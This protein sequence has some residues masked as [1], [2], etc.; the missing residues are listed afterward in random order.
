MADLEKTVAI[1]FQGEDKLSKSITT[2]S[3]SLDKFGGKVVSATQPLADMS[4]K[5]L[6]VEAALAAMAIGGLAL[7][8]KNAGEFGDSF[9]EISTLIDVPRENLEAFK[10]DIAEYDRVSTSSIEDINEAIYSAISA[11]TDY[12]NSLEVLATSEKLAIAG[13]ADLEATTR[14]L[15]STLNAY[16]YSVDQAARFSDVLFK[17]VK[18][19]Q[20]TLPE[21]ADGLAQVSTIAAAAGVPIETMMAGLA[22][23]T[24][25]GAPVDVAIT[26]MKGAITSLLKPSSE[27]ATLAKELGLEFGASAIK[28]KGF[29]QI[30]WDAWEATKGNTDQMAI[31]FGNVRALAG[32]LVLGSDS[33]GKFRAS[34]K[35]MEAAA[36]ATSEAYDRMAGNFALTNQKIINNLRVTL[37]EVGEPLLDEYSDIADG[38]VE[39][40][41]GLSVGIDAGAFDPV[42][43]SLENFGDDIAEFLKKVAENLPEAMEDLD[44]TEFIR[45]IEGL[46]RNLSDAFNAFFGDID[47]TTPEGLSLA[48]QKIVD[49]VTALT[50]VTSGIIDAW[51]PFLAVLGEAVE[52]FSDADASTQEITG[53]ILGFGQAINK[54]FN[55]IGLLTGALNIIAGALSFIAGKQLVASIGGFAKLG[56]TISGILPIIGKLSGLLGAGLAG[57]EIGTKLR[58]WIPAIDDVAQ[59]M[60]GLT[61][62]VFNWSG[63][64]RQAAVN[65][66]EVNRKWAEAQER[67][68]ALNQT[69]EDTPDRKEIV[70]EILDEDIAF[71][72][73]EGFKSA[74]DSIPDEKSVTAK[75]EVDT[76]SFDQIENVIIEYVPDSEEIIIRAASD[77]QSFE[78]TKAEIDEKIPDEKLMEI[79][80]QGDIETEIARINALADT[81]QSSVEWNAKLR[82]AEFEANS[83][84]VIAIT[85]SIATGLESTGDVLSAI[86]G[87]FGEISIGDQLS[88]ERYL[89]R[90]LNIQRD[91]V[92]TQRLLTEAQVEFIRAKTE[93]LERGESLISI[94]GTNLE[95]EL[96]AFMLRILQNIQIWANTEGQEFLLGVS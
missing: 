79:K 92:D 89:D 87:Q 73:L 50:N 6:K 42:F 57:W 86:F 15:V 33:S 80:L 4:E 67:M 46:G 18:L 23:I 52:K 74:V 34:L 51:E 35:E 54:V 10:Q 82:I 36:G 44:F 64:Q 8:I 55:N 3:G 32:A 48:M 9:A 24:A 72:T 38:L 31:L 81:V 21:L 56:S 12:K 41:Q 45:S 7:A 95:P 30:L 29:E 85:E 61:D 71:S 84:T 70:L 65:M 68:A 78:N 39:I 2:M 58:E 53:Q 62:K 88:L 66:E 5:V 63:T 17:T 75:A 27:A 40:F 69:V 16:G 91:L 14:L 13:K 96:E 37:I 47:L 90:E 59:G 60:V 25:A 20:V 83:R 11:G 26:Q 28:T 93:A 49:S 76:G 22:A 19:G 1:I 94:D 77:D 43:D